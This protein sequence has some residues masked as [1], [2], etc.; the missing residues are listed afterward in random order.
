MIRLKIIS[1]L[2]LLFVTYECLGQTYIR[3][4][5]YVYNEIVYNFDK[6]TNYINRY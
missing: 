5:S 1:L 2:I 3:K 4:G 6:K